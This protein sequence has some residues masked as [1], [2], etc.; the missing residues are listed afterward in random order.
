MNFTA[1]FTHFPQAGQN[2]GF[3]CVGEQIQGLEAQGLGPLKNKLQVPLHQG[4]APKF[5]GTLDGMA[6]N[7][8]LDGLGEIVEGAQLDRGH[9]VL[10]I[11]IPGKDNDR[12]VRKVQAHIFDQ[13]HAGNLRHDHVGEHQVIGAVLQAGLGF[14][15]ILGGVHQIVGTQEILD[16]LQ[17]ARVVIHYQNPGCG[18]HKAT[19]LVRKSAIR[20]LPRI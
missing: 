20:Q 6:Q 10:K 17:D 16:Q 11:G 12:D 15:D 2:R 8:G 13:F 1:S 4:Q 5:Q 19:F 14:F 3:R 9:R 7:L 18:S